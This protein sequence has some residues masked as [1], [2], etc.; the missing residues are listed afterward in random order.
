MRTYDEIYDDAADE[1]P[2]SNNT[3]YEIWAERWCYRC[4][5]DAAFQRGEDPDGCPL[6]ALSV[7][8]MTPKEFKPATDPREAQ[9][10][11]ECTE[12]VPDDEGGDDGETVPEPEPDPVA[13]PDGQI[14]IL[15]VFA[16][17]ITDAVT[18]RQSVS[19]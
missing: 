5:V 7:I 6:L 17:Q 18:E 1:P 8:G 16:E 19:A 9:G 10:D 14:D 3:S 11:Y 12:F 15:A 4:K 2:F 13:E